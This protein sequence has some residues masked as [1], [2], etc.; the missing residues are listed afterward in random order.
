MNKDISLRIA[1][2]IF[3]LIALVHLL[4][5]FLNFEVTIAGDLIPMWV[6]V[7]GFSVSII[8]AVWMFMASKS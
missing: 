4:R 3:S 2:V 7:V 5:L 8:F 6:S 1:G